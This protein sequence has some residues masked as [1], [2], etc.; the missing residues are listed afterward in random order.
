LSSHDLNFEQKIKKGQN[1]LTNN[2]GQTCLKGRKDVEDPFKTKPHLPIQFKN[3]CRWVLEEK[4]AD[5]QDV[6]RAMYRL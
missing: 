3:P 1:V 5:F 6:T 2:I 4:E